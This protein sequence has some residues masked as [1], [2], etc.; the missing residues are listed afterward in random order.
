MEVSH[1]CMYVIVVIYIFIIYV[2]VKL[3]VSV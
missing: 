2:C 3:G 1:I